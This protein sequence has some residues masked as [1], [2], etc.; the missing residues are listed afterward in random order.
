MVPHQPGLIISIENF[1]A[2]DECARLTSLADEHVQAPP[3]AD[4]AP[5]KNE[6]FLDRDTALIM[7]DT[8]ATQIWKRLVPHLPDIDGRVPVG[9]HGDGRRAKAGQV[10]LYRYVKGQQFGLHVDQSWKGAPGE[11]TE[12]TFLV[13]LNS[14]GEPAGGSTDGSEQPLLGG[15]TVFMKTAKVEL[16]R[17]AP[18][19]G[20]GLLHAHGRRCLL[21]EGEEV[22][23]GVKYL[24]RADIMYRRQAAATSEPSGGKP[25]RGRGVGRGG[26]GRGR[27]AGR[28]ASRGGRVGTTA[29]PG[30][31][32]S[33][34]PPRCDCQDA[35]R[36]AAVHLPARQ[37][38]RLSLTAR[39][40]YHSLLSEETAR[41][42]AA[43]LDH[44]FNRR[45]RLLSER[46]LAICNHLFEA[47]AA[48]AAAEIAG[49]SGDDASAGRQL[50][51]ELCFVSQTESVRAG[52]FA[53]A[54]THAVY[55][56]RNLSSRAHS[57][58]SLLMLDVLVR[59]K[60][61]EQTP[62]R[63]IAATAQ[64][65]RS[66]LCCRSKLVV[67]ALG[68]GPGFE[69]ASV[70]SLVDFLGSGAEVE[71][72]LADNEPAWA[73]TAASVHRALEAC[74]SAGASE[75]RPP[76]PLAVRFVHADVTR[77]LD[78]EANDAL[79]TIVRGG[80]DLLVFSYVLVETAQLQRANDWRCLR[81]CASCLAMHPGGCYVVALDATHRIWSEVVEALRRGAPST[82]A[83]LPR[84]PTTRKISLLARIGG[85]GDD[86]DV[87]QAG[88]GSMR[89]AEET[90]DEDLTEAE[91]PSALSLVDPTVGVAPLFHE[92]RDFEWSELQEVV[93]PQITELHRQAAGEVHGGGGALA[94]G[95][96]VDDDG[97]DSAM[98]VGGEGR[99][100]VC[101]TTSPSDQIR[102]W[103][104]HFV[105]HKAAPTPFFKERRSLVLQFPLLAGGSADAP[106]RVLEVGCGNG[107][108]ALSL[109]RC[110]AHAIV[111]ATDPSSAAVEQTVTAC[112]RFGS[113]LTAS[114]QPDEYTP[115]AGLPA[116]VDV[117]MILFTLSAVPGSGDVSLLE[118]SAKAVKPGGAVLIRDYGLYDTRHVNDARKSKLLRQDGDQDE[119]LRPGGMH[120]RYYSLPGV[121]KLA[122]ACGL[123]VE[124][125]RLLCVRLQNAKRGLTMNRVYLH[126]VLRR[127]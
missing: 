31:D 52:A 91:E 67:L 41:G 61:A 86:D 29:V 45:R 4:L 7:D 96:V 12:F 73:A 8:L 106:L 26:V 99:A 71:L 3:K 115:A 56:R 5:K 35:L 70:A 49:A 80:V 22:R 103:E 55:V 51:Q 122:A 76:S 18:K 9:L 2:A 59:G 16:C 25:E 66:L 1:L 97:G 37:R 27:G 118:A 74:R 47:T 17:V 127:P 62:A 57:L 32:A 101:S 63:D 60:H 54:A 116:P 15:D 108:S 48:A 83:W 68:G 28:G 119:Y 110:N 88:S 78:D 42:A 10:K 6:A 125:A 120:R 36:L 85:R 109:L 82:A 21:H 13:Y 46:W 40:L 117:A 77:G 38:G 53:N 104:S 98:T 100:M 11:E 79:R 20:L 102:R 89:A 75:G 92:S 14:H 90:A 34:P 43:W 121:A 30:P 44:R 112:A 69:A 87:G 124:E 123:Q 94:V 107:S 65:R 105:R 126:A 24:M 93:A 111:H 19:M 114:V 81:E 72:W 39:S 50:V 58:A 84:H 23:R 95:D 113:R 33:A 64:A